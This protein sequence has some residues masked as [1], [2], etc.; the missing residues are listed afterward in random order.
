MSSLEVLEARVVPAGVHVIE[1]PVGSPSNDPQGANF[2]QSMASG[3]FNGDGFLDLIVGT[4][5]GPA[6]GPVTSSTGGSGAYVYF[7]NGED[8][9]LEKG[10]LN[11]TNGFMIEWRENMETPSQLLKVASAGDVNGDGID[12][13]LI[14]VGKGGVNSPEPTGTFY[15]VFGKSGAGTAIVDLKTLDGSNGFKFTGAGSKYNSQTSLSSGDFNG[16]GYSDILAA[17][18]ILFGHSGTF[19]A[20]LSPA[21]LNGTNGTVLSE[22]LITDHSEGMPTAIGD[23][24][25]DGLDDFA[26]PI[27]REQHFEGTYFDLQKHVI[28]YGKQTWSAQTDVSTADGTNGFV[29][30]KSLNYPWAIRSA[31]DVNGDGIGDIFF[32]VSGAYNSQDEDAAKFGV[33]F[34][35]TDFDASFSL[36]SLDGTNGFI[37]ADPSYQ[38]RPQIMAPVGDFN[39]DGFDDIA[40]RGTTPGQPGGTFTYI[41]YGSAEPH[42][43]RVDFGKL[44]KNDGL[45]IPTKDLPTSPFD[46]FASPVVPLGDWDGDGMDDFVIA[47]HV[48]YSPTNTQTTLN[49]F[50]G[51]TPVDNDSILTISKD[52]RTATYTDVDGD[53]VTLKTRGGDFRLADFTFAAEGQGWKLVELDVD[54]TAW[55]SGSDLSITAAR[56]KA[57]GGDGFVNIT[58][59]T[60]SGLDLGNV[61]IDGHLESITAGDAD[62]TTSAIASLR[63]QSLGGKAGEAIPESHVT[64]A[65]ERLVIKEFVQS[66]TLNA[67]ALGKIDI[68]E[69]RDFG[70]T[71]LLSDS[72]IESL[73]IRGDSQA[74]KVQAFDLEHTSTKKF[75][76]IGKIQI[77]GDADNTH[78]YAG[79]V[80]WSDWNAHIGLIKVGGAW[81]NSS[82]Q[83][84]VGPKSDNLS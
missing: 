14:G 70:T 61:T 47:N 16:D 60:A 17:N 73:K 8:F 77:K 29:I 10:P 54:E 83:G 55:T 4:G 26:V 5:G 56:S 67:T 78:I 38:L 19:A 65:L 84:Q 57:D 34:G 82:V 15:V 80:Y 46:R 40:I 42:S 79:D 30:T 52:G 66:I 63:V 18:V 44:D 45:L 72:T 12:D 9:S 24:N 3:D 81:T 35:S 48:T 68:G 28:I 22:G 58:T 13:M 11:G 2:G 23:I 1:P 31:G 39:G 27:I 7:G 20:G 59:L 75:Q 41:F 49:F 50:G 43:A 37:V 64:G 76:A 53:K 6:Y 71:S 36:D 32:G 74:L 21:D 33:I 25:G 51:T 69:V 62:L